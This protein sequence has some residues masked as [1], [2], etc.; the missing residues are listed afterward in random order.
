[1]YGEE[2]YTWTV[3]GLESG[4]NVIPT[5]KDPAATRKSERLEAR[6]STVLKQRL[7]HAAELRGLSLTDFVVSSAEQAATQTISE[8]DAIRL[9]RDESLAFVQAMLE[10]EP[11]GAICAGPCAATRNALGSWQ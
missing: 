1:V 3:Y 6:I 2:P 9:S 10:S 8:H 4:A 5:V 11:A 7:Q